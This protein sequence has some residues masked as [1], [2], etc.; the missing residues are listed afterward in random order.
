VCA[1]SGSLNGILIGR[2]IQG[3]GAI[4]AAI[5]ALIADATREQHRTK[6]MAMVG[7]SIGISFA[8]AMVISPLL[9]TAIGMPGMFE[10]TAVLALAAIA[11]V[12]W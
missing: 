10:M 6:A 2:A 3:V 4:S 8:L 12:L 9:Y 1:C 11:V 7:G 5:T